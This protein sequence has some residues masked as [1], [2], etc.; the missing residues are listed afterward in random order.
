MC[1]RKLFS[2]CFILFLFCHFSIAQ[3]GNSQFD[4]VLPTDGTPLLSGTFGELRSN[5]F[6]AGIDIKGYVGKPI[7]AV[8]EGFVSRIKVQGGGY[9]N[10]LYI[11]HPNGYTSVYAHLDNYDEEIAAY[12]KKQQYQLKNFEVDLFPPKGMFSFKKGEKIG[13]MGVKG[14]SFGPHLHFELRETKTEMPVN[15]LMY[16]FSIKDNISPRMHM[17]KVYGLDPEL[18]TTITKEY[19]LIGGNGN[20]RI[21]GDTID[22]GAWRIGLGIKVYDHMNGTSNWNGVYRIMVMVDDQEVYD[23]VMDKFAFSE[24]RYINAHLDYRDVVT[25]KSYY[26]RCYLLPGNKLSVYHAGRTHPIVKLSEYQTKKVTV[27]AQDANGNQSKLVF[28]VKRSEVKPPN[29]AYFN[30]LFPHNEANRIETQ[31][32]SLYLPKGTLYQDL[33]LDYS[34]SSEADGEEFSKVHHIHNRTV[35]AHRY[36][37]LA[38]SPISMPKDLMDKAFIARCEEDNTYVNCG[39]EWKNGKLVTKV[40]TFG[41][42]TIMIDENPPVIK[43]ITFRSNMKGYSKMSF[44]IEDDFDTGGSA[45]DL[46][47]EGFID[48]EWVLFQFDAKRNLLFHEFEPGLKGAHELVLNVYDAVGN[49]RVF[50]SSFIR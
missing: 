42:Y 20:Y 12:V 41:D 14:Y 5:H 27:V 33:Y 39:G 35:P 45:K 15:P 48:G 4:F 17:L 10:A 18:N 13:E 22:F 38:I 31:D 25:K 29:Q 19:N 23:F 6:H 43:L 30:Y 26:N 34:A 47:Y 9:G 2:C 50:K 36:F 8:E 40:R 37:E 3:N 24:S 46:R 11:S 28:W 7:Y 16:G 1:V 32:V 44:Q 49:K 21:S